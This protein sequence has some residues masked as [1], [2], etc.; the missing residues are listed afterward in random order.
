M[1]N[2]EGVE[3]KR[4]HVDLVIDEMLPMLCENNE[5][6]GLDG[7]EFKP[8]FETYSKM[9]EL[10][11][12][13]VFTARKEGVLVGYQVIIL[14]PNLH[15]GYT[16]A[17]SDVVYIAPAHRGFGRHFIRWCDE[18]LKAEGVDVSIKNITAKRDMTKFLSTMGYSL[19]DRV[20]M[21][22]FT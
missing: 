18:Q 17:N 14:N 22:R 3:F 15:Y 10:G 6:T 2:F 19:L 4:E 9:E 12:L 21:K 7:F 5:E 20:Y 8:Q 1:G 13:R 11:Y 16:S